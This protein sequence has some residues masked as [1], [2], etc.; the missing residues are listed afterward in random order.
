MSWRQPGMLGSQLRAV[1]RREHALAGA[2]LLLAL[3]LA[4]PPIT[5]ERPRVTYLVTFDLTQSMDVEDMVRDGRSLS[6]L[7]AA[8]AAV[9]ELLP[10]LPCGSRV[11]WAIFADYRTLPLML[12]VEVCSHYEDLLAA[13]DAID[14]RMRWAN[15]SNIAKGVTW[16]IRT[17]R[18][19]DEGTRVLFFTDGHEAPPMAGN[20]PPPMGDITAGEVGG[21][22]I[23]V[24]GELP[25][26][27]PKTTREGQPAGHW[28]ADEVVQRADRPVGQSTEHLSELREDHL[29][30]VAKLLGFGYRRLGSDA[31][32]VEAVLDPALA[33]KQPTPTD[34]RWVAALAALVLLAWRHRPAWP[35]RLGRR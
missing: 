4:L 31:A 15:A 27:I 16:S 28:A 13:L 26:P 23:G 24:G 29:Q 25:Q 30:A 20:T 7:D 8:R 17:A 1:W 11:G 5:L 18:N 6:R 2:V 22:L 32:L 12:P 21:L 35:L 33:R 3:A 14:G 9:R 19:V 10:R 34:L